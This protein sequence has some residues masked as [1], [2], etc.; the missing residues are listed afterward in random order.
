MFLERVLKLQDFE[1]FKVY[2][3]DQYFSNTIAFMLLLDLKR[4]STLN[5]F[6]Y[7]EGIE[8]IETFG[9]D[10]FIKVIFL[11]DK[12][13]DETL[14][15][16]LV[17]IAGGFLENKTNCD[18]NADFT[19]ISKECIEEMELDKKYMF[20]ECEKYLKKYTYNKDLNNINDE[21]YNYLSQ[22]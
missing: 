18:W 10:N 17:T 16:K 15:V 12:G 13:I 14:K 8:E 5:D 4:K 21:K 19:G 11:H 3:D 7:L 22:D 6:P 20:T 2:N 9:R 1:I